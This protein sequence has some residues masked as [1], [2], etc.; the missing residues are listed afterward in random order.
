MSGDD[1]HHRIAQRRYPAASRT[2]HALAGWTDGP[3]VDGVG[4]AVGRE[5]YAADHGL[6]AV[7]DTGDQAPGGEPA[8][9][10]CL[11]TEESVRSLTGVAINLQLR[12]GHPLR[13]RG[14]EARFCEIVLTISSCQSINADSRNGIRPYVL[15]WLRWMSY[16]AQ[17]GGAAGR[18]FVERS[19]NNENVC[20]VF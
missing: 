7:V 18:T 15:V 6:P 3:A 5:T 14:D 9:G 20:D 16:A 10:G 4:I 1:K 13:R 19:R 12:S 11:R 2:R 8:T 17:C